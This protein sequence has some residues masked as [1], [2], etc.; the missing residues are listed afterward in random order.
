MQNRI[1]D[2]IKAHAG[3]P[4]PT[5]PCENRKKTERRERVCGDRQRTLRRALEYLPQS[6]RVLCGKYFP[7]LRKGMKEMQ[8]LSGAESRQNL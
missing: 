3:Q 7:V 2:T 5:W 6:T 4:P 1:Q 8:E